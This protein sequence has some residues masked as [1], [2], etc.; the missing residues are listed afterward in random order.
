[1]NTTQ[2]RVR[3]LTVGDRIGDQTVTAVGPVRVEFVARGGRRVYYRNLWLERPDGSARVVSW[4][5]DTTITVSNRE[6]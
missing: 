5:P 6:G 3:N 1:M 2:V 4:R